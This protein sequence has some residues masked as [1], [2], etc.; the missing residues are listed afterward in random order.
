[1]TVVTDYTG[2]LYSVD[3]EPNSIWNAVSGS[4]TPIIVTYSFAEGA[5]LAYWEGIEE[6]ATDGFS[7]FTA[8]QRANFRLALAVYEHA[9]G[10]VFVESTGDRAMISVMNSTGSDWS[11]WANTANSDMTSTSHGRLVMDIEGNY[12]PGSDGFFVLLHELGHAMGLEH[13]WEGGL[14]LEHFSPRK[15]DSKTTFCEEVTA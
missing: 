11:G 1:M 13:P 3:E 12:E 7:S 9:M 8:T 2:I 6:Q 15:S 10:V 14:T 4:G 5:D